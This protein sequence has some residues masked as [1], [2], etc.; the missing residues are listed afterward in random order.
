MRFEFV[1]ERGHMPSVAKIGHNHKR[2]NGWSINEFRE[3]ILLTKLCYN[4]CMKIRLAKQDDYQQV[5][6]MYNDFVG[7]KRYAAGGN[8][9][10]LQVLRSPTNYLY[11]AELDGQ[12]VGFASLS[13]R[14]VV[15][16]PK[17]IAE[18]DELYV[19]PNKREHGIGRQLMQQIEATAKEQGCYRLFIESHYKHTAAHKF[20]EGLGYTNNG[21]HFIK[22]M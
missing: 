11:V 22:D 8:D 1:V 6:I 21:Y 16:Y 4:A 18:L 5:M 19:D 17:L 7:E 12:L 14:H 13:V 20:Y 15:R 2:F 3:P 10:F 9:S